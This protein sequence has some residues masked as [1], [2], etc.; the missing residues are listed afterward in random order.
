MEFPRNPNRRQL[1]RQRSVAITIS[2]MQDVF[3]EVGFIPVEV[4]QEMVDQDN[5]PSNDPDFNWQTF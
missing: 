3:L 1:E 2:G 4:T 5:L